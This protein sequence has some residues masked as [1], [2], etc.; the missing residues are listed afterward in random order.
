MCSVPEDQCNHH[1]VYLLS[2]IE[3]SP[4]TLTDGVQHMDEISLDSYILDTDACHMRNE[5]CSVTGP[6]G[7]ET[8][9]CLSQQGTVT[10]WEELLLSDFQ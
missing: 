4:D 10:S 5:S 6:A 7:T 1:N 8:D 3:D 2:H 9:H